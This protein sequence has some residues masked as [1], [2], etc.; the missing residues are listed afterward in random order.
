MS[1][2][3]IQNVFDVVSFVRDV[4]AAASIQFHVVQCMKYVL[5]VL[6]IFKA[7]FLFSSGRFLELTVCDSVLKSAVFPKVV[8]SEV[9]C[10]VS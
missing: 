4:S 2:H 1:V 6:A 8:L 5:V 10:V 3:F 9:A 7:F